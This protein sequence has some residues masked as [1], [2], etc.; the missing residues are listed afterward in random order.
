MAKLNFFNKYTP[1]SNGFFDWRLQA[2][3]SLERDV[4]MF[5]KMYKIKNLTQ[6]DVEQELRFHLWKKLHLFNPSKSSL[7]TWSWRVLRNKTITLNRIVIK[8][9]HDCLDSEWRYPFIDNEKYDD[10]IDA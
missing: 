6:E 5:A 8:K 4:V 10:K 2:L 9:N 7:R 3:N 1:D